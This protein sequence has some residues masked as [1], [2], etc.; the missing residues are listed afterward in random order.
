MRWNNSANRHRRFL[1]AFGVIWMASLLAFGQAAASQA[2][3]PAPTTPT[4]ER[5][6]LIVIDPAHGGSDPGALLAPDSAEKDITLTVARRLRQELT[7]RGIASQLVRD[8]DATLSFDQRAAIANAAY[9]ALY[10][11]VHA[12]SA[13]SGIRVFTAMLPVPGESR[14]PFLNW[15]SAQAPFMD[16]SKSAQAQIVAAVQK[17]GFP[18]RALIA[19][20][21]PLNNLKVPAI[22]VEI[23]PANGETSQIAATGYQQMICA[24]LANAIASM[25]P[26]LSGRTE[27]QP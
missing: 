1:L 24:A 19:P 21:R 10:V 16:R 2:P 26:S 9:P 3:P 18:V 8:G 6:A 13:G 25:V 11:A 12:S 23:S 5:P 7:A 14:G 17:T 27:T 4:P 20:L 15:D 22:A